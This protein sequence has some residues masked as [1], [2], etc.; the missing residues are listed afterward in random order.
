MRAGG[1]R[2]EA[3]VLCPE[4]VPCSC[5]CSL[6]VGRRP[7]KSSSGSSPRA[8]PRP[9]AYDA[10]RQ[11]AYDSAWRAVLRAPEGGDGSGDCISESDDLDGDAPPENAECF[12]VLDRESFVLFLSPY[13]SLHFFTLE[14]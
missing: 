12:F 3:A 8:R 5:H 2:A 11:V 6:D 9:V 14:S 7:A 4:S 13:L 1:G 10:P